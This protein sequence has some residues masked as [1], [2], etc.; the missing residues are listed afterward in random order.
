M[1]GSCGA[2]GAVAG[3]FP[4]AAVLATLRDTTELR[5]Q[6]EA[7]QREDRI[8]SLGV[9]AGGIAHDFNNALMGILGHV[10]LAKD[11]RPS[12]ARPLL[13]A[14]EQ[15]TL[16]AS[17]LTTQLL[18]FAKGGQPVR[19][20]AQLGRLLMDALAL[21][22][23]GSPVRI[24]LELPDE[25]W[26]AEVDSGQFQQ[27]INNLVLNA[28]QASGASGRVVVRAANVDAASAAEAQLAER[29]FVRIDVV[30]SGPGIPEA[31]RHRVFDPYFTTKPSGSGLGLA[32]AFAICRSHDGDLRLSS[33]SGEATTL[34]AFF[35]AADR[36]EEEPASEAAPRPNG[37]GSILVLEDDALVQ[38]FL[39]QSLEEWGYDVEAVS[40]GREAVER[41]ADGRRR[42]T[43]FD[44]LIM[45]L[46][47]PGGMGGREAIAEIRRREPD[48]RAIVASGYSND[49]TLANH[50]EAGFAAALVKPFRRE[51]LARAV[52]ALLAQR[53]SDA[54]A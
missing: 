20:K 23:A 25:L 26:P 11:A 24:Q 16:A 32:T 9:L 38:R 21:A 29:R 40:D 31:L 39:R 17:R 46:T 45:D 52:H 3:V 13:D 10:S 2:G 34:S 15:A 42:G 54:E 47:I 1:W 43:P 33:R 18:A 14:A 19:R 49:P 37:T 50:R 27:V 48:V 8:E 28:L 5:R 44:L 6:E 7:R 22:G 12:D 35:P 4:R 53:G 41:H 51:A 30:D 36:A